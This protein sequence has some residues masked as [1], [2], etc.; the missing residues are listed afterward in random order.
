MRGATMFG[1]RAVEVT[2]WDIPGVAADE[3]LVKVAQVALCASEVD[4]YTGRAALTK[5]MRFGHE[6]YGQVVE[7]GAD[8]TA[9]QVGTW[10]VPYDEPIHGCAEYVAVP[11]RQF[12][13]TRPGLAGGILTELT[14]CAIGAVHEVGVDTTDT[15]VISGGTGTLGTLI[16]RCL[17]ARYPDLP[18]VYVLG[19]DAES[20]AR[21]E[22][23]P[24][25]IAVDVSNG[26]DDARRRVLAD[27]GG[28]GAAVV[29][30]ASGAEAMMAAAPTFARVGGTV[31]IAG[32]PP[33]GV[34]MD[35]HAICGRAIQLRTLHWRDLDLKLRYMRTAADLIGGGLDVADL[36]GESFDLAE[37]G[38]AFEAAASGAIRKPV[39]TL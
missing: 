38:E 1:P 39:V 24:R 34:V 2:N 13:P 33:G 27:T 21:A 37:V 20:L 29:L 4:R 3:I 9:V 25:T 35:W 6:V 36:V 28:A 8:V 22:K 23:Q 11:A 26:T 17:A 19:R 12:V 16:R 32:Y 5:P 31:G 7:V 10:G 14:A 18:A 15:V 30:E